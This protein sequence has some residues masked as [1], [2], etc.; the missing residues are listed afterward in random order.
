VT[1][2]DALL[3]R[4]RTTRTFLQHFHVVVGFKH[5]HVRGADAFEHELGDVAEIGGKTKIAGGGANQK[6]D[7]ILRVVR[8]RKRFHAHVADVKSAAGVKQMPVNFSLRTLGAGVTVE[9]GRFFAFPFRLE[10]PQRGVLR[11]AIAI[12]RDVKFVREAEQAADVVAVFVR[13]QNGG[14]IFRCAADRREPRADL[15]RRKSRVHEDAHLGGFQVG[16]IA[17]GTAAEDGEFDGHELK[18]KRKTPS[19]KRKPAAEINL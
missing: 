19:G 6:T 17:A 14:E 4:P 7:R 10:R 2:E 11:A 12:N 16:A 9:R 8:N 1:A 15:A 13:E 18:L 3:Q 5:E